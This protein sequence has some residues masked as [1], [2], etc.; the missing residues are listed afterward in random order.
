MEVPDS[1]TRT[2][3]DNRQAL[4]TADQRLVKFDFP[5]N[6]SFTPIE[7]KKNAVT[8]G[9]VKSLNDHSPFL[10]RELYDKLYG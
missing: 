5:K 10:N 7:K 9:G 1:S 4:K 3:D 8:G 2:A 6:R